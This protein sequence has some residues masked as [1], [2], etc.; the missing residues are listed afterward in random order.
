M[1]A[2]KSA[3]KL[4]ERAMKYSDLV[5]ASYGEHVGSISL[6]GQDVQLCDH[7]QNIDGTYYATTFVLNVADRIALK[8]AGAR[9]GTLS[10]GSQAVYLTE[11][12]LVIA[13]PIRENDEMT[14]AMV[15]R[16]INGLMLMNLKTQAQYA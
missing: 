7:M 15:K 5:Q 10:N 2:L 14:Q 13:K 1:T 6:F 16:M 11:E 8:R 4:G 3:N 12:S 9:F